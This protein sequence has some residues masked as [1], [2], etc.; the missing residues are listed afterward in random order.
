M[1]VRDNLKKYERKSAITQPENEIE[2]LRLWYFQADTQLLDHDVKIEL[3]PKQEQKRKNLEKIWGLLLVN[4]KE[5][6]IADIKLKF[7]IGDAAARN[8]VKLAIELFGSIDQIKK[9]I[10]RT[11]RIAKREKQIDLIN[12]DDKLSS[13]EKYDLIHRIMVQIEK[14][15]G[16]DKE[17]S[18][19]MEEVLEKLQLP[20]IKRSTDPKVLEV[21]E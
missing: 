18:L 12:A 2:K 4:S 3:T 8:W 5:F 15:S 10:Q 19:S 13:F 21:N 1:S 7:K 14:I 20:D 6:V 11:L 17:D 9:D 16:L